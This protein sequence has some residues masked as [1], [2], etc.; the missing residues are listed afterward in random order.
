MWK[1][2]SVALSFLIT[3]SAGTRVHE[4]V[5]THM[6]YTDK[7]NSETFVLIPLR[8]KIII[9]YFFFLIVCTPFCFIISKLERADIDTTLMKSLAVHDFLHKE[10]VS[11]LIDIFDD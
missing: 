5:H 4:P 1:A 8:A 2:L 6:Y 10:I 11:Y 3:F 7:S 9:S